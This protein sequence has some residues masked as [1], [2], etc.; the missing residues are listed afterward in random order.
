MTEENFADFEEFEE[1]EE[2][3]EHTF[4]SLFFEVHDEQD[5]FLVD[6][7]KIRTVCEAILNDAGVRIGRFGV[8][9]VDNDTIHELNRE[10]L[11]H[12]Y[13]TDV[14]SFLVEEDK[15]SGL[16]EGEVI[17]SAEVAKERSEEFSWCPEDEL[18]LYIVH[19]TLHLVGYDDLS[20]EEAV[21]MREKERHYL[22]LLD[23]EVPPHE[24]PLDFPNEDRMKSSDSEN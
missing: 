2:Q 10:F 23:I 5:A 7:Q 9:I 24:L 8:A 3:E 16:L 19:G 17:V 13:P 21:I 6:P 12:D 1:F 14:L 4:E 11:D 18:L 22:A 15:A 20:P